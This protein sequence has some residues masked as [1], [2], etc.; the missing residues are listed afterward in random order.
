MRDK[1]KYTNKKKYNTS[2]NT[3]NNNTSGNKQNNTVKDITEDEIKNLLS[4]GFTI[5]QIASVY[6]EQ[7]QPIPPTVQKMLEK[8]PQQS[9]E[10]GIQEQQLNPNIPMPDETSKFPAMMTPNEYVKYKEI[11]NNERTKKK[12]K[13]DIYGYKFSDLIDEKTLREMKRTQ[14]SFFVGLNLSNLFNELKKIITYEDMNNN[15]KRKANAKKTN[16]N[17]FKKVGEWVNQDFEQVLIDKM[18]YRDSDVPLL[19]ERELNEYS[20]FYDII[21]ESKK[22]F[23][24]GFDGKITPIGLLLMTRMLYKYKKNNSQWVRV[25]TVLELIYKYLGTGQ[26]R[27]QFFNS[28]VEIPVISLMELEEFYNTDHLFMTKEELK[29]FKDELKFYKYDTDI[30]IEK[31]LKKLRSKPLP[32]I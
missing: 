1:I 30:D 21:N 16:N 11:E 32:P 18:G 26:T 22:Y 19:P 14:G 28:R 13:R 6:Q 17:T 4:Q 10:T 29:K 31:K 27:E 5:E 20:T 7:G 25:A 24:S 3:Q 8:M 2:G 23:N 15:N 12:G 9:P